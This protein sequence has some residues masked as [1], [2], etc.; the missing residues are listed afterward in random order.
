MTQPGPLIE[1]T[2]VETPGEMLLD[3]LDYMYKFW[4]RM[5]ISEKYIYRYHE[6]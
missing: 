1:W 3:T 2:K 6:I 5:R 4:I